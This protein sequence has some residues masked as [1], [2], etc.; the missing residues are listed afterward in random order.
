MRKSILI[1]GV[2][3]GA[4]GFASLAWSGTAESSRMRSKASRTRSE[5]SAANARRFTLDRAILTAIQQNPDVLRAKQEL[6]RTKGVIIEI[7]AQALPHITPR[8][9]FQWTDPNLSSA[10]LFSNSTAGGG[11]P[12]PVSITGAS[13]ESQVRDLG[14]QAAASAASAASTNLQQS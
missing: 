13:S 8:G 12:A 5:I 2:L 4:V 11:T 7:R 10:R 3:T 9:E 1:L 6:E 14:P